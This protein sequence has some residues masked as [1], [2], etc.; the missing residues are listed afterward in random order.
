MSNDATTTIKELKELFQQ[1]SPNSKDQESKNLSMNLVIKTTKLM[2][3]FTWL[4]EQES[5][6]AFQINRDAIEKE[7]VTII[8]AL[9]SFCHQAN[10]DLSYAI[11]RKM[12]KT[13]EKYPLS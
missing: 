8:H 9:L 11:E 5:Y 2:E 1:I 3:I 12:I 7:L 13:A 10:I 4:N 6:Q